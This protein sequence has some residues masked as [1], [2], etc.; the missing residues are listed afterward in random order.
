MKVYNVIDSF[1]DEPKVKDLGSGPIAILNDD[2]NRLFDIYLNEDGSLN[3]TTN[4]TL[5][6]NGKILDSSISVEP[7]YSNSITIKR[8]VRE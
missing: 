1:Q 3:V 6:L 2:G 4:D 5:L 8:P 7:K